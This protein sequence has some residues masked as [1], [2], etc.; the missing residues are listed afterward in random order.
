[1]KPLLPILLA[2]AFP[3]AAAAQAGDEFSS[4]EYGFR[5][6]RPDA[7]WSFSQTPTPGTLFSLKTS[8]TDGKTETSATVFVLEL[9]G[10]KDAGAACDATEAARK[11]DP[12]CSGVR[13]GRGKVG[14]E[15]APWVAFEYDVAGTK[16]TIRQYDLVHHEMLFILQ[17]AAPEDEFEADGFKP[18][19]KSFEFTEL[20]DPAERKTQALLRELTARCGSEIDWAPTWKDAAARA[21]REDRLVAVV[22][23]EY[24]GVIGEQYAPSALFMDSDVVEL[25]NARFVGFRWKGGME[26]PFVS[27]EVYGLG[28]STF[29]QGIL[30]ADAEGNVVAIGV[31][32]NPFYFYDAARA[33]L[34]LRPGGPPVG[35]GDPAERLR[36][37]DFEEAEELLA[38]PETA[39]EFRLRAALLR[40]R[41]KGAEALKAIAEARARGA[42]GA[43][44]D[45]AVI[46]IRM[47]QFD[48]AER[49]LREVEAPEAVFW[50]ALCRGMRLGIEPIRKE[51]EELAA[52]HPGDRWA[53]RGAA[54]LCGKGMA[55]GLDRAAWPE[56]A[57]LAACAIAS[58]KPGKDA[59]RAEKDAIRFL[60]ESQLPDGSW[61]TPMS[62][63]EPRGAG[64]V[65]VTSICAAG[66]LPHRGHEGVA[67]AVA[68]ALKFV[69]A[70]ELRSDPARL[71]DY[72]I[73]GQIFSLRFFAE[74]RAAGAGDADELLDAM[75]D[76][77]REMK[78][79]RFPDGGWAYFRPEGGGGV[80]IG[81]VTA[82]AVCALGAAEKAGAEVPEAMVAKAVEVVAALRAD[83]GAFG[84][85]G[86][87]QAGDRQGEA[88]LRSPM[89]ALVLRRAGKG[90][91]AELRAALDIYIEHREHVRTERGKS[92][93]H[94]SPEGA[95]SY[96]LL[97]GYA[98]SAESL[99][100]LPEKERKKYRAAL[101]EDVL[102]MRTKDGGFCDNSAMG[103]HYGAGMAL[104][105]LKLMGD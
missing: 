99:S 42:E 34:K 84:Y 33:A 48:Q 86:R 8:R 102:Y 11:V 105:A 22:V 30:F 17:C 9:K 98:W 58:A 32:F 47:G 88:S 91:V 93:C 100:E 26:A 96:Y 78:K 80:S 12:K 2:L 19:L 44:V 25:M 10:L 46:R 104:R 37:G 76:T 41:R 103:R 62:L 52:A 51:L 16:Y 4:R 31:S 57:R 38:A 7:S 67:D 79:G 5:I 63:A 39:E 14:G 56:E 61:P 6:R 71:F 35:P 81:F 94:T 20:A 82:A 89:Y 27:P 1:M 13:R 90:D 65:A 85:M 95:A 50:R 64:A 69:L 74:C 43:E 72:T 59:K 73:W 49:L 53:W 83:D 75:N 23:E 66:L 97:Y 55:S 45:E 68:R 70:V 15:T 18:F 36:R 29:G 92:L 24:R 60:L 101:L 3:L 40:K 28:P 87:P 77:V 54:M 21:A